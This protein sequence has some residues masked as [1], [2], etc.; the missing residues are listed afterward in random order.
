MLVY[1]RVCY[2][3][4]ISP[5]NMIGVANSFYAYVLMK[6]DGVETLKF[7]RNFIDVNIFSIF[8]PI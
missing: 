5:S 2:F 4:F 8:N 7:S 3:R 1:Q 6:F